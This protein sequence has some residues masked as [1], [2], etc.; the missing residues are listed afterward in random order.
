M[1]KIKKIALIFL[2]WL[3]TI[4]FISVVQIHPISISLNTASFTQIPIIYWIIMLATPFILYIIAKD[5]K[6]P[7]VP[8][9][10]VMLYYFLFYSVGLYF[11]SHPTFSDIGS[12]GQGQEILSSITHISSQEIDAERYISAA[13][14]FQWPIMFIFRKIFTTILGIGPIQTLNLGFFSLLLVF[15]GLLSLFYERT[16]NVKNIT[17]YFILP[18]L[19]LTLS[20]H[21]INDQFVPQFLALLYLFILFGCYLKYKEGKNPLFLLLMIIYYAL[22]VY[23]HAFMF[24]FFLVAIIFEFFWSEYIE[25][26]KAKFISYGLIIIIIAMLF[27]YIGTFYSMTQ[28]TSGGESWRIFRYI[29]PQRPIDDA[30]QVGP[31]LQ[32]LYDLVPKIYN[33]I[34]T[35]LSKGAMVVVFL[36]VV[37]GFLLYIFK[38]RGLFNL[39]TRSLFDISILIGSVSWFVLGLANLVLGQRAIQV[40]ALPL[41]KYFKYSHRLFSYLSKVAV[42]VILIAPSIFIANDMINSSIE[43]DRLI[44]DFEENIAG[45]FMDKHLTNESFILSA[46]NPYPAGYPVGFNGVG[47]IITQAGYDFEMVNTILIS[48]KLQKRAKYLGISLPKGYYDSVLYDN[49]DIKM[50]LLYK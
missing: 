28:A 42:V 23:T 38:K 21:F 48:P 39:S 44:Q 32:I 15:P 34:T 37:F 7:L 18:A 41:S 3:L 30:G 25:M 2:I 13:R 10:C 4:F 5:S 46:Q 27:P 49:R 29:L 22:T 35:N 36:T 45:R 6:N 40:A 9:S 33:T 50:I 12:A 1:D 19:Y 26:K 31:S 43:G 16:K 24:I 47:L 20:W 8:L 17:I 11:M 14:Y